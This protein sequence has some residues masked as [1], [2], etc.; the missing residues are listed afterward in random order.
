MPAKKP[1]RPAA[2]KPAAKAA[3]RAAA[4]AGQDID[5]DVLIIGGGLAGFTTA[6]G[7]K[8]AGLRVTLVEKSDELGGRARSWT[9]PVTGDPVHIGPHIFLNKY[10]NMFRLMEELGTMDLVDWQ[11]EGHFITVVHGQMEVPMKSNQRL[12]AP[13]HFTRSLINDKTTPP[14][15]ALS[16]LPVTAYALSLTEK[17]LLR[18]DNINA[19]AFLRSMGVSEFMIQHFWGFACMAIM[20][21]PVELCSAGA[22]LRFYAGLVGMSSMRIGFPAAG[23]SDLYIPQSLRIMDTAGMQVIQG[24]GV[25]EITG[26]ESKATGALLEDG[27]RI[28][29][30]T[31]V[32]ALTPQALRLV[33]RREWIKNYKVFHDLVYFQASPYVSTYLWFDRKLT[34]KK[35]WARA[36]D[37]ND[38]NCDFYDLSNINKGWQGRNSLITTNCIYCERAAHMSDEEIVAETVRELSEYLPEAATAKLE[39][40]VVNRIPMAIHCPYPGME[41]RRAPTIT[42]VKNL[43]LA[44]DWLATG[45]PSCMEN[46]CLTGWQAA[47]AVLGMHGRPVPQLS[48]P[49]G[50]GNLEGAAGLW[51]RIG[52]AIPLD[53]ISGLL[54]SRRNTR[55]PWV[56]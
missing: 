33:S 8:D 46:A 12:P 37:L 10:P 51:N 7:L 11:D 3:P 17:E 19:S 30:K 2:R 55:A 23:L 32:A 28:R 4:S 15:H 38:L 42:P 25:R 14:A 5:T 49:F 54:R 13:F 40:A 27:R 48:I 53:P 34:D 24:V 56:A 6:V 43:V 31:V 18:L 41:Q 50:V 44:G 16:Q 52:R 9:D 20:N 21:V 26:D 22:L 1:A 47:E 45:L 39:H 35:F 29:A 36:Y